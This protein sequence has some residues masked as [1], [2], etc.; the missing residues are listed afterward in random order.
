[1]PDIRGVVTD[2]TFQNEDTGFTVLRLHDEEA[3]RTHTCVGTMPTAQTGES[4][5]VRGKEVI[6]PRYG[7][8]ISVT[9]Y[10]FSRPTTIAGITL[11]LSSGLIANIGPSR[12]GK[13]IAAFGTD[14]LDILDNHPGRLLEVNGIGKK[15][16]ANIS[17]AWERQR[18]IRD[19][20][21]YLQQF[22]VTVNLA[23][24]IYRAYGTKAR[25]VV[26]TNPYALI[27]DIWGVGF[28]KADAIARHLGFGGDSYRRIKAGLIFI[29]QEAAADGH[30]YLPRA[31]A[32]DKAEALLGVPREMVL[33][34]V[35]HIVK[36]QVLIEE[37]ERL[38]LPLYHRTETTVAQ[39]LAARASRPGGRCFD[40]DDAYVDAWLARHRQR[41]G[42]TGDPLQIAA[43][44]ALVHTRL[45][46]LTGGPGTGKTTT[47][48]VLVAFLREHAV[49]VALAAP[50]GRAAQRMGTISGI[51]AKTIHR[52]LEFRPGTGAF[53]FNRTVDN[54]VPAKVII[55]DEASM[56][57]IM[58]MRSLLA[59]V[60]PDASL[61]LVGDSNQ[62]PSVGAGNVLADM[63]AC[64]LIPHITL[65]TIF[66]QA[67]RSRIV[68]AAHEIIGGR[69]PAFANAQSD[70]LFFIRK[71]TPETCIETL[72]DLVSSRLP[73]KYG[74]DPVRDIQVLSPMH[75]GLLGTQSI[76]RLLQQKLNPSQQTIARGD[77]VFAV[78]DKVMQI[79]NNYDTSVFNGDIGLISDIRAGDEPFL[80]VDFGDQTIRYQPADLDELTHAYCI[81]IHKSQ[82]C[83]FTA[84]VFPCMTQHFIMLQRT[85]V[86]TAITRARKLCVLVGMTRALH[87][88]VSNATALQRYS[89]L[90]ERI[91]DTGAAEAAGAGEKPDDCAV[92]E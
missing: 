86:Y 53:C 84:V 82:G 47:L 67:A 17:E 68:T 28:K 6:S 92:F 88:A 40:F 55:I 1:M 35:D 90:A 31:E 45:L 29:M 63:I 77:T 85:L 44:K 22:G 13:I 26:S 49:T 71:D 23:H 87:V 25:E 16:L 46:L 61:I 51:A 21:L 36:E 58:L 18:Y 91:R 59:A 4:L 42:W 83:E 89:G 66:R 37:N 60:P 65:A 41:T 70:N 20:L 9:S 48:Q 24:K 75:K 12:A 76:N 57:D 80:A 74:F 5:L 64:G 19:L 39:M 54:P 27:D 50:T 32:L 73:K 72:I 2:I 30:T 33:Y 7:P 52:L 78:G 69:V 79:R 3:G 14:T 81:S 38:F 62:L 8:Q 15:I 56:I 43:V 34:S 10:E 11:L